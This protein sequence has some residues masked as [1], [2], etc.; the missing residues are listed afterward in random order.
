MLHVLRMPGERADRHPLGGESFI[1]LRP[2]AIFRG[3]LRALFV[4][5][6]LM[7]SVAPAQSPRCRGAADCASKCQAGSPVACWT[8]ATVASQ[9]KGQRDLGMIAHALE[10]GC[11]LGELRACHQLGRWVGRGLTGKV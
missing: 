7:A 1:S 10:R 8:A 3:P 11:A 9:V 4:L 6:L 5:S 2:S